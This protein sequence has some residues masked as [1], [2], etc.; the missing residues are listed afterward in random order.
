MQDFKQCG[1]VVLGACFDGDRFQVNFVVSNFYDRIADKINNVTHG[2][3][4]ICMWYIWWL[5][6]NMPLYTH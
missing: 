6:A 5:V 1:V 3:D 4:V 2:F